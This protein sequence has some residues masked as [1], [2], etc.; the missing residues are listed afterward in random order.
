[1]KNLYI[2]ILSSCFL[3]AALSVT[4]QCEPDT[5]GCPDPEENGEICPD[6]LLPAILQQNYSEVITILVP[7]KPSD[8]S[9][10]ELH[11]VK[12]IAI[13]NLP[14]GLSW[15]SNEPNN[16]FLANNYYCMLIDGTPADTG[17]FYLKIIVEVFI[18][19]L[20]TPVSVGQQVDS[21]S[22]F[23]SVVDASGIDELSHLPLQVAGYPNPFTHE[24]NID[25][26]IRQSCKITFEVFDLCGQQVHKRALIGAKGKNTIIFDGSDLHSGLY[27]FRFT[28]DDRYSTSIKVMKE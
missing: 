14:P 11:H 21:T 26:F 9:L 6:T 15:Q 28:A 13:D 12:L 19:F 17:T 7:D 10:V 8:T 22:V 2:A 1:M 27:L 25:I 4:G 23:M 16:E 5:A 24:T 18:D 20:G 3:L